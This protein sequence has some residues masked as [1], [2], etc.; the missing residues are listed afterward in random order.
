LA[1]IWRGLIDMLGGMDASG[2]SREAG[3]LDYRRGDRVE[4]VRTDDPDTRLRPGDQGTV[5]RWEPRQGRLF[6]DWDS[7]SAL[8]MLSAEGDEVRLVTRPA[9]TGQ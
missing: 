1:D 8:I 2:S 3:A 6:I 9:E 4:L 7:G 5:T